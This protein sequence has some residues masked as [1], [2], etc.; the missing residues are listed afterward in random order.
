MIEIQGNINTGNSIETWTKLCI[1]IFFYLFI[2]FFFFL[3]TWFENSVA[4][5]RLHLHIN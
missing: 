2:F 4:L 1:Y 5:V 3:V